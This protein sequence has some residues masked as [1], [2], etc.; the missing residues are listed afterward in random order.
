MRQTGKIILLSKTDAESGKVAKGKGK[1]TKS[2][3]CVEEGK[4]TKSKPML[5]NAKRKKLAFKQKKMLEAKAAK[6]KKK[7][8][9]SSS[10][11]SNIPPVPPPPPGVEVPVPPKPVKTQGL[12]PCKF[13]QENNCMKG[14]SCPYSHMKVELFPK[15]VPLAQVPCLNWANGSCRF[16]NQCWRSHTNEFQPAA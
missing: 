16:G 10:Q 3:P 4:E 14:D 9:A 15:N 8:A 1:D 2:K 11:S 5:S 6:A 13:F 12:V 7:A